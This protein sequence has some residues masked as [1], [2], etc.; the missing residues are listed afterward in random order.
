MGTQT[1]G[2]SDL[3]REL[4]TVRAH[5]EELEAGKTDLTRG[6]EREQKHVSHL[7][8]ELERERERACERYVEDE[9]CSVGSI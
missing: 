7:S 3:E 9:L 8:V 1:Q 5:N 2:P 6:L 4:E